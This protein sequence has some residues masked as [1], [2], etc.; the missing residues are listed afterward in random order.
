MDRAFGVLRAALYRRTRS[1]GA[2][3]FL[4]ALVAALAAA[5][6]LPSQGA[7]GAAV[8]LESALVV[9]GIGASLAAASS[10]G[11]L[12]EDRASG[13]HAWLAATACPK[14]VLRAAP[15]VAGVLV[16]VGVALAGS[17]VA[18]TAMAASD[19]EVP[20]SR[21][22]RLAF[23][24]ARIEAPLGSTGS[25]VPVEID[26]RPRIRSPEAADIGSV[27][28]AINDRSDDRLVAV[29]GRSLIE[30]PAGRA[31]TVTS[32]DPAVD[33][34]VVGAFQIDGPASFFANVLSAG[35]LLGFALASIAP[36]AV[37]L[38]RFLAASTAVAA[39]LVLAGVGVLHGPLLSLAA[40]AEGVEGASIAAAILHG[41][42][43]LAP[44]LS[45][46][47]GASEALIGHALSPAAFAGLV[48]P[49][50]HAA[51]AF[52]LLALLPARRVDA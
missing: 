17:L 13:V 1:M 28:L 37:L 26:F 4:V 45:V 35:L 10:A 11:P 14:A 39:A 34:R 41:A 29:R 43:W 30:L 2:R 42:T 25:S 36:I 50:I 12:P 38:S 16:T 24:G 19:L 46:V 22:T 8:V 32:R 48:S 33:L 18:A 40:D 27:P 6:C 44:D 9:I 47:S 49:A 5:I 15:A 51:V 21:T 52:L 3:F 23:E 20:T 7:A 31:S